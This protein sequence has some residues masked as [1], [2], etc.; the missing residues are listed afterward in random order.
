MTATAAAAAAAVMVDT[1]PAP[2][3]ETEQHLRK[4]NALTSDPWPLEGAGR[5]L[6][7]GSV[8]LCVREVSGEERTVFCSR[9][10][11]GRSCGGRDAPTVPWE[12]SG[13]GVDRDR[14][15]DQA[16]NVTRVTGR[17]GAQEMEPVRWEPEGC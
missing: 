7:G 8:R 4:V 1:S 16:V 6:L 11:G 2:L 9:C 13:D 3:W 15:Q 5:R 17:N 14:D 10:R 12:G